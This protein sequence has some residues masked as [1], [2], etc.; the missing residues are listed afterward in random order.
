VCLERPAFFMAIG[1]FYEQFPQIEDK[2]AKRMLQEMW[3]KSSG[4]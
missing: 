1:Q 3:R 4:K 2:I